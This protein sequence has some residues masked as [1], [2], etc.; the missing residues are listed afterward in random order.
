[1]G[2]VL[3]PEFEK[4][5]V[6]WMP[7]TEDTSEWQT[8]VADQLYQRKAD[9]LAWWDLRALPEGDYTLR[10]RLEKTNGFTAE[11]R[12]RFVRDT[13]AAQIE[14]LR[15]TP[16]WDNQ[17]RKG[18]VSF[19]SSDQGFVEL[20]YRPSGTTEFKSLGFDR[21][22]RNGEFLLGS[23]ILT[24]GLYEMQVSVTNLAGLNSLSE[25]FTIDFQSQFINR[26]GYSQL[27]YNLPM[28]RFLSE[29]YDFDGDQL[30]EVVMSEYN[31][32]LSFGPMTIYEFVGNEFVR[33]D[34]NELKP[35]L[36]P[37]DVGDTDGDGL[38]EILASVNDSLFILEQA[39]NQAF[40]EGV[41]YRNEGN[42]LYASSL[43]DTDGDNQAE[44]VVK[45]FTDY[46]VFEASGNDFSQAAT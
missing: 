14:I 2:T 18:F 27:S 16:I 28:G 4:F 26:S 40:P 7:G 41:I 11:D 21:T 46:F 45:D 10:I 1:M 19:R 31:E 8:L 37:K 36:I 42:G 6:E 39:D 22:T 35:I 13:S 38:L 43:A 44:L 24:S 20:R 3:D 15:A 17:E 33:V 9:T 5:H 29:P 32:Q 23:D 25:L 30:L 12:I 34:S